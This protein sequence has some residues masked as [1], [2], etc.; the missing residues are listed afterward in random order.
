VGYPPQDPRPFSGK[1]KFSSIFLFSSDAL[2]G[3]PKTLWWQCG[4][5]GEGAHTHPCIPPISKHHNRHAQG[6]K[7][8]AQLIQAH[9]INQSRPVTSSH[10]TFQGPRTQSRPVTPSHTQSRNPT[11][12]GPQTQSR[13][14]TPSHAQSRSVTPSHIIGACWPGTSCLPFHAHAEKLWKT[15]EIE[16]NCTK[17]YAYQF[18]L[19]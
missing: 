14:V 4:A 15:A 17:N 19:P 5:R 3:I 2:T 13:P 7:T 1:P 11:Y 16:E 12:G 18:P 10:R 6:A 9:L 8:F